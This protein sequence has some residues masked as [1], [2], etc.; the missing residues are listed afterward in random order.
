[1][2][3]LDGTI[4]VRAGEETRATFSLLGAVAQPIE[5]SWPVGTTLGSLHLRVVGGD[6]TVHFDHET[7]TANIDRPYVRQ[8]GLPLGRFR[9]TAETSS[10]LTGSAELTLV[11]LDAAPQPIQL[12]LR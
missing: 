10:G 4:D 8:V 7:G 9:I 3:H 2:I 6:G 12:T 1:M 11:D 5:I